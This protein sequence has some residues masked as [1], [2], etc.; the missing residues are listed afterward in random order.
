MEHE[1]TPAGR[2]ELRTRC[3]RRIV[4]SRLVIG[5][6]DPIGRVT[7]RINC[8]SGERGQLWAGLTA[9]EARLLARHLTVQAGLLEDADRAGGSSSKASTVPS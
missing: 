6:D 9:D 4:V 2:G 5:G 8:Q 7:V 1:L 3:G